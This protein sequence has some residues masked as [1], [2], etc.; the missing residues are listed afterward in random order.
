MALWHI[1]APSENKRNPSTALGALQSARVKPGPWLSWPYTEKGCAAACTH[2]PGLSTLQVEVWPSRPAGDV[3]GSQRMGNVAGVLVSRSW[4][5]TVPKSFRAVK[6]AAQRG[7]GVSISGG[8][9]N[10]PGCFFFFFSLGG[11]DWMISG[12]PFQPQVFCDSILRA[13]GVPKNVWVFLSDFDII[14]H[15]HALKLH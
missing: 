14:L 10:Q 3:R 9:Q 12:G 8:I 11:L 2:G 7:Y 15:Q 5:L 13:K 1:H 6:Q 4:V